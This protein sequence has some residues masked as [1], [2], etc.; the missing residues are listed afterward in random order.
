MQFAR[1]KVK[2]M[3]VIN[4]LLGNNLVISQSCVKARAPGQFGHVGMRVLCKLSSL[5]QDASMLTTVSTR[6]APLL[7]GGKQRASCLILFDFE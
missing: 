2:G 6:C 1:G 5:A 4:T 3:L 7:G